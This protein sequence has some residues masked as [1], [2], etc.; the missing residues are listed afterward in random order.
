[1]PENVSSWRNHI[2]QMGCAETKFHA[3]GFREEFEPAA[4]IPNPI[5]IPNTLCRQFRPNIREK[6]NKN[7]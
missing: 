1:M 4:M 2:D 6:I 7:E 5:A 3:N